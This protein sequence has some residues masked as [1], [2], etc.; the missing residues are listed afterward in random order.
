VAAE[1]LS[2]V[3]RDDGDVVDAVSSVWDELQ[4]LASG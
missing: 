4:E 2:G 1:R 3:A